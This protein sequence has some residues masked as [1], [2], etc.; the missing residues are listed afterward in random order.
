MSKIKVYV[1]SPYT[2]G[3]TAKNVRRQID[4][5][6]H[7]MDLGFAPFTPLLTHFQHLV[8]PRDYEDWLEYDFTWVAAC[9]CLLRLDG[10]SSGADR[11]IEHA[12]KLDIPVFYNI[13]D[14]VNHYG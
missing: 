8:R 9:D 11:E 3:D 5:A 4:C 6:D 12:R 1:A 7:L 13:K 2:I 14:L 10:E